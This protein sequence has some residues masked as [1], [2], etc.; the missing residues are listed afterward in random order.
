MAD[1]AAKVVAHSYVEATGAELATWE[2][3]FPR[4]ILAEF[5]T[6]RRASTDDGWWSA[7]SNAASSRAV[8][9][10]KM[11][12]EVKA[13]PYIPVFQ[14][15]QPGMSGKDTMDTEF[16]RVMLQSWLSSR[17]YACRSAEAMLDAG[18]HKTVPN[19]LLEPFAMTTVVVSMTDIDNFMGQ[20]NSPQADPSMR[21]LAAV[22]ENALDDST[23]R[24]LDIGEWHL[25]YLTGS[26][27]NDYDL[28]TQRRISASRCA[29]VSYLNQGR[30]DVDK[31]L[32]RYAKLIKADPPHWSPLEHV[33]TP[34]YT[35]DPRDTL[36]NFTGF[37]Q[38]RHLK[39]YQ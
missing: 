6:H 28:A 21:E 11:L 26:E 22:M 4:V 17:D 38:L 29:G 31:D 13:D 23:P 8:P 15:A 25:P 27:R 1:I 14:K 7:S 2:A 35:A 37:H 18:S 39:E 9:V 12:E 3:T 24:L 20:R 5:N 19:R 10:R 36:G 30:I 34:A 16:L 33:A 32:E